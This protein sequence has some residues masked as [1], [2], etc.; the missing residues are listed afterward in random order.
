MT[1]RWGDLE[2]ILTRQLG[3]HR[4]YIDKAVGET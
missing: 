3:R 1:G 2:N 4:E